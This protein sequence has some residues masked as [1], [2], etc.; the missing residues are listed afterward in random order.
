MFFSA[1]YPDRFPGPVMLHKRKWNND[2]LRTLSE[3]T[4]SLP[5]NM[6]SSIAEAI[7]R[8]SLR[9]MRD[10]QNEFYILSDM[11]QQ[12]S[13][14]NFERRV[15]SGRA[16]AC[17]LRSQGMVP[18]WGES[19]LITICGMHPYTPNNTSKMTSQNYNAL[20]KVWQVVFTDWHV[21]ATFS[22]TC[23]FKEP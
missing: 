1:T 6:G 3:R 9:S 22:E 10:G 17:W 16:F 14:F 15:P 13:T 5:S 11:R 4:K 18:K 7:F 12:N 19:T 20:V 2:F 23:N 8:A 21:S